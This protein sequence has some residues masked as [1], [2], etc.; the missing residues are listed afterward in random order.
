MAGIHLDHPFPRRRIFSRARLQRDVW[1][2]GDNGFDSRRILILLAERLSVGLAVGI[3]QFLATLLPGGP[4]FRRCDIPIWTTLLRDGSKVLTKIFKRGAAEEPIP[5]VDLVYD[6]PRFQHDNVGNHRI[7]V[8]VGVFGNV[9]IFLN[10]SS[11]VAQDQCQPTPG[12]YDSLPRNVPP[13]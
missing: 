11:G 1:A 6:Q 9:E 5:V 4:Q 13:Q 7:V 3:K 8:G 10:R 12:R 2:A